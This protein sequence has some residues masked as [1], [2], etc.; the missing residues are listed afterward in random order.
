MTSKIRKLQYIRVKNHLR[1]GGVI[2]DVFKVCDEMIFDTNF[3]VEY[4]S[5]KHNYFIKDISKKYKLELK[6]HTVETG[7]CKDDFIRGLST[8]KIGIVVC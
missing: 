7:T 6:I 2:Y 3:M 4:I 8:I 1:M 5:D